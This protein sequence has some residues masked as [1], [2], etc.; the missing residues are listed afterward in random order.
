MKLE[1]VI[2]NCRYWN[3]INDLAVEAFPPEEYLAPN[4][5]LEMSKEEYFDFYY[6][7]DNNKFIGFAVIQTYKNLSYLFFLAIVKEYRSKG[8]GGKALKLIKETYPNKIQVVDFEMVDINSTNYPQRIKRRKFYLKNGYRETGF[9]LSYLG[10]DY[11]VFC[12]LNDSFDED[13]FKELMT[14]INVEK[15]NPKYFRKK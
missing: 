7:E 14:H 15:F 2:K 3:E 13:S 11:E 12:G 6:I 10:V 5:L 1:K 8:Y 4:K 9:F